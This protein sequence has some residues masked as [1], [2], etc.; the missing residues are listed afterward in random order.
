MSVEFNGKI[1]HVELKNGKKTLN[2]KNKEI[3]WISN[4][5]GLE[6]LKDLEV[7]NLSKNRISKITNLE[8]LTSL[9]ELQLGKNNIFKIKGIE[10][11]TNLNVLNLEKNKIR[12][13]RGLESLVNL[14]FL[15]LSTNQI[16]EIKGLDNLV[17]LES[18][19]LYENQFDEIK[20]LDNLVN[21]ESL[22]LY[23]NHLVDLTGLENLNSLKNLDLPFYGPVYE[24]LR[25]E[26]NSHIRIG[27]MGKVKNPQ[28]AVR[29]CKEGGK[30]DVPNLE[31]QNYYDKLMNSEEYREI[32]RK[33]LFESLKYS[34]AI[35]GIVLGLL[36]LIYYTTFILP[37]EWKSFFG[38]YALDEDGYNVMSVI[39]IWIFIIGFPAMLLVSIYEFYQ[40][41]NEFLIKKG[42]KAPKVKK[43]KEIES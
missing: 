30:I 23:E 14:S 39:L 42:L 22:Y 32:K 11:L 13:I 38:E 34:L 6:N 7:L 10:H 20:G 24:W 25:N 26:E 8:H 31:I 12:E 16:D 21:L 27:K 5:K 28:E 35:T 2:L 41:R 3:A 1:Y 43:N 36:I 33:N 40:D 37:E 17:N 4:I 18:L 15:D 29:F 19:Y 9:T